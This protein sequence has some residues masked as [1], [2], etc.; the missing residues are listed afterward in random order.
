MST[1]TNY[2]TSADLWSD[3]IAGNSV[4]P[5]EIN[6]MRSAIEQLERKNY[7]VIGSVQEIIVANTTTETSIFSLAVLGGSL[8][9]TG[10]MLGEAAIFVNSM[11]TGEV[12][13]IKCYWGGTLFWNAQLRNNTGSTQ[14]NFG[15]IMTFRIHNRNSA[16]SQGIWATAT[17]HATPEDA[18]GWYQPTFQTSNVQSIVTGGSK[19]TASTQNLQIQIQWSS[20]NAANNCFGLGAFTRGRLL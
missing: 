20:A 5:S 1:G 15:I 13:S 6:Q 7:P 3:K 19:N 11:I 8:G 9:T 4:S 10:Y 12:M 16:L 2:P 18:V 17:V 14:I